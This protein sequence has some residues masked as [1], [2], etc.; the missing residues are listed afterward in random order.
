MGKT[1]QEKVRKWY[2]KIEKAITY[3]LGTWQNS[4][5]ENQIIECSKLTAQIGVGRSKK[6]IVN[7]VTIVNAD[8]TGMPFDHTPPRIV[9]LSGQDSYSKTI[10]NTTNI[11]IIACSSASCLLIPPHV[12][13]TGKW[14]KDHDMFHGMPLCTRLCINPNIWTDLDIL[15][16]WVAEHFARHIP[17]ARPALLL[18]NGH[19]THAKLN[20]VKQIRVQKKC[21]IVKKEN[22]GQVLSSIL[23]GKMF[24]ERIFDTC[25]RHNHH[26]PVQQL[27][28]ESPQLGD[29][30]LVSNMTMRSSETPVILSSIDA[31]MI[32]ADPTPADESPKQGQPVEIMALRIA[33]T[34]DVDDILNKSICNIFDKSS[35]AVT[36]AETR[37][38]IVHSKTLTED[39]KQKQKKSKILIKTKKRKR[40]Q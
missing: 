28:H 37:K 23:F 39:G 31:E 14:G 25:T 6:H 24:G 7:L 11:T 21:K 22:P 4:C 3:L 18:I 32:S 34:S 27:L 2:G 19:I 29:T 40:E 38:T 36:N 10:C 13:F 5:E 8:A 17:P 15:E 26:H 30:H 1:R 33:P 16:T 35:F 20:V 12:T 9:K